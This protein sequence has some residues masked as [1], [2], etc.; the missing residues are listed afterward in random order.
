MNQPTTKEEAIKSIRLALDVL[1]QEDTRAMPTQI[2]LL[3]RWFN[4]HHTTHGWID[5]RTGV[6]HIEI[7]LGC[8]ILL[9]N[10]D[11]TGPVDSI[12]WSVWHR[13]SDTM[14]D[15]QGPC[16]D[17]SY[18][19]SIDLDNMLSLDAAVV[20]AK[21]RAIEVAQHQ[22]PEL[23]LAKACDEAEGWEYV[24]TGGGILCAVYETNAD[25]F[26]I[27]AIDAAFDK[28]GRCLLDWRVEISSTED[29]ASEG[30]LT[31][32]PSLR[33]FTDALRSLR[34]P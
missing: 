10:P 34:S 21:R 20:E 2:E 7:G 22:L 3:H 26:W 25:Q 18:H 9:G 1:A 30:S 27:S 19:P 31:V 32:E 4:E 17:E 29:R 6:V 12:M 14:C 16:Y 15:L 33:S 24:N 23:L 11:Q 5:D 28:S 13:E 8:I